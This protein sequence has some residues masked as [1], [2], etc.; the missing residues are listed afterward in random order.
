ME[1]KPLAQPRSFYELVIAGFSLVALPLLVALVSGAYFV[2]R[3]YDQSQEAVYRAV[4]ATQ[5]SRSL[6]EQVTAMERSVR[7]YAVLG[8]AEV[9]NNYRHAH[10]GFKESALR[11]RALL[12]DDDLKR[13]L[14]DLMAREQALFERL[15]ETPDPRQV[16]RLE[17]DV[18]TLTSQAQDILHNTNRLIESEVEVLRTM[19]TDARDVITWEL[20][21]VVPGAVIFFIVFTTLIARPVRQVEQAI[22][23]LG[24]GDFATP[25]SVR[26]PR[27]L[28]QLG[29][30]LDWLRRRL[31]ELEERKRKFLSYVSHELKT[32]LT[33]IR[34]SAELLEEGV[35]GRLTPEQQEV[36]AILKGNSIQLQ[37]MIEKMLSFNLPEVSDRPLERR[38]MDLCAL[39]EAVLADHKPAILAKVLDLDVHCK[40]VRYCG[41]EDRL[42]VVIDNLVSNAVKYSPEGGRLELR[43]DRDADGGV[44]LMVRDSGPGVPEAE[45]E[46]IFEAFYRG[47]H[48]EQERIKGS[49][50]GLAI[51]REFVL[52]HGG[53]IRV[54]DADP[55]ARFI[56]HLPPSTQESP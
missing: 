34:E 56:V 43:L 10:Q 18:I 50:L 25:I 51:V 33:A 13:T 53:E 2:G 16:G 37:T 46:R 39:V 21:A 32:P 30:R 42:R 45:R 40:A 38:W 5:E 14:A 47:R 54:E 1:K 41:D 4:L 49:G 44:T 35:L 20:L 52:A 11:L 12:R 9:L 48:P 22:R 55:G 26:G 31:V 28:E 7:Q 27:D 36:A 19:A 29:E 17:A 6:F 23:R 3:L 15:D 8:D 24:D